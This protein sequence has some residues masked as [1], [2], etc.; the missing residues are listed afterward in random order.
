MHYTLIF[1]GF[2]KW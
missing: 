1:T 2:I